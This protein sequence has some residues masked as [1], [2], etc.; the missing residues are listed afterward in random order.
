MHMVLPHMRF[1]PGSGWLE[2]LPQVQEM[3]TKVQLFRG[4]MMWK[5]AAL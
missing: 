4:L 1:A 3:Q 5:Q 2:T